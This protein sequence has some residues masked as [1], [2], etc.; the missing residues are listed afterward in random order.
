M[1]RTSRV[2]ETVLS[3]SELTE[4]LRRARHHVIEQAKDDSASRFRIDRDIELYGENW[5][6]H[7][8]F[9]EG[10]QPEALWCARKHS[11]CLQDSFVVSGGAE[12][13]GKGGTYRGNFA[14]EAE[15]VNWRRNEAMWTVLQQHT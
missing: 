4:I 6:Y 9:S 3:R 5:G 11:P 1:E 2:S 13:S 8:K 7:Q 14:A 15:V 12:R 10:M